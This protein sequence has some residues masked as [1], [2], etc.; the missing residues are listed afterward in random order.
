MKVLIKL[1]GT[2][3]DSVESRE[4]L[5]AEIA[6]LRARGLASCRCPWRRQA[7][8]SISERARRREPIRRRIAS[9]H[10]RS[11]RRRFE[12]AGGNGESRTRRVPGRCRVPR[13]W[14]SAA[15]MLSLTEAEQMHADLGAVGRPIRSKPLILELLTANGYLPVVACV[16]RR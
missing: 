12:G 8:D 7:D 16:G 10:A 6:A 9:V 13:R 3:L 2:L 14:A 11:D 5:A 1:G 4:R 15:S